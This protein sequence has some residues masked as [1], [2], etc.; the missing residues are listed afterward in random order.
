MKL[1]SGIHEFL[2][3]LSRGLMKFLISVAILGLLAFQLLISPLAA[4]AQ[5]N[6]GVRQYACPPIKPP[7]VFVAP[8]GKTI[9]PPVIRTPAQSAAVNRIDEQTA[10]EHRNFEHLSSITASS[11]SSR[12]DAAAAAVLKEGDAVVKQMKSATITTQTNEKIPL[13]TPAE[14]A[15]KDD[16]Y[17]QL[18]ATTKRNYDEQSANFTKLWDDRRRALD[19]A[20]VN[21]KDQLTSKPTYHDSAILQPVGTNLFVRNYQPAGIIDPAD[22]HA[23]PVR[24]AAGIY[25]TTRV[26]RVPPAIATPE[27]MPPAPRGVVRR[28]SGKLL[29]YP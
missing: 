17:K 3:R 6:N 15:A 2:R 11:Y 5:R 7:D 21:L 20:A 18:A 4:S 28:I 1:G 22:A 25:P 9:G 8:F 19:E 27:S 14:I 23:V 12:G 29:K 16:Y 10:E 26:S 13:Y 24:A